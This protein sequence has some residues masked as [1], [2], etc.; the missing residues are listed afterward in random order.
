MCEKI[1]AGSRAVFKEWSNFSQIFLKVVKIVSRR[2]S[3]NEVGASYALALVR[4][5][6]QRTNGH[7]LFLVTVV[8]EIVCQGRLRGP[9]TG[10]ERP[11]HH[12]TAVMVD[13]PESL[14]H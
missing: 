14:R 11:V 1:H 6:H 7:P 8:E 2:L 4:A 5:L 10:E 9:A 3:C 12:A 13:I